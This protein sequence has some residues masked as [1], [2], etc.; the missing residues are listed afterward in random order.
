MRPILTLLLALAFAATSLTMAAARGQP[1]MAGSVI[2]C[3][4]TG[5]VAVAVDAEGNPVGP[6]HLC[7]DCVLSLLAA[8]PVPVELSAPPLRLLG[9][10]AALSPPRAAALAA[11][12]AQSRGPPSRV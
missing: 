1:R 9:A 2:L 10:L 5:A 6:V 3:T 7:P 11:P 12:E 4:G 8:T